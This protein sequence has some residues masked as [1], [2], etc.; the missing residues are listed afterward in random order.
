MT[1]AGLPDLLKWSVA[2]SEASLKNGG[3]VPMEAPKVEALA[4][5]FG[6]NVGSD[7][8]RMAES[9]LVVKN[10]S[11]KFD[12]DNR[13]QA[14]EDFRMLVEN[15]DNAN[16]LP[17]IQQ[18]EGGPRGLWMPLLEQLESE[19]AEIRSLAASCVHAAVQN[20][21]K[22]QEKL[23]LVGGLPT[24]VRLA[25]TDSSKDVRKRAIRALNS[26]AQNYQ[27]ALDDIITRLPDTHKPKGKINAED[28]D[29]LLSWRTNLETQVL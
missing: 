27:P 15:L 22:V 24:L 28:A 26:A 21:A 23:L 16:N 17:N 29:S 8:E 4:Q 7:A 2:N 10:E 6:F 3:A 20:D 19:E 1:S 18:Y 5:L 14:F 9:L 12:L 13:I 11:G 25:T